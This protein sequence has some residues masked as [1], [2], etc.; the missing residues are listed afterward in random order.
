MALL[1]IGSPETN[2]GTQPIGNEQ[3]VSVGLVCGSAALADAYADVITKGHDQVAFQ[4]GPESLSTELITYTGRLDAV[5][6]VAE[7]GSYME[8]VPAAVT[9][10]VG[11]VPVLLVDIPESWG[12]V[13]VQYMPGVGDLF[14]EVVDLPGFDPA[15]EARDVVERAYKLAHSRP[16]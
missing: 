5:I 11:A 15:E 2:T 6:A 9:E 1:E 12:G 7:P 13:R 10:L 14:T 4:V 8:D 16:R 3:V